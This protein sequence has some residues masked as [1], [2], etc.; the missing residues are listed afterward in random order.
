MLSRWGWKK[1]RIPHKSPLS[2]QGGYRFYR[3]LAIESSCDDSCVALLES[4]TDSKITIVDHSKSTLSSSAVGGI[5]PT[6]AHAFHQYKLANLVSEFLTKNAIDSKNPPDIIMC[7]R[8]PGLVGSLAAGLQLA[9]GL[10]IAWGKP[11]LGVHHMLGHIMM[12]VHDSKSL[13]FPFLSLLAS[14]GHTMLVLLRSAVDHEIIIDTM[15]V[16]VG[17]SLDKC[18]RELGIR[19]NMIGKELDRYVQM[20]S[21]QEKI[22]FD[23]WDIS[24]RKNNP[25]DFQLQLPLKRPDL[26]LV[27]DTIQFAFA[28]FQSSLQH[29][30][31]GKGP[32]LENDNNTDKKFI[33]YRL[34]ELVFDHIID[35]LNVALKK[36]GTNSKEYALCDSKF[37]GINDLVVSGGVAANSRLREKLNTQLKSER[38]LG[39]NFNIHIP[40]VAL[41]TDNAVMIGIAGI[42]FLK[43]SN[44]VND[45]SILPIPK[46]PLNDIINV[47][48]Y[49]SR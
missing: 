31:K 34:Q 42:E 33:A 18:G 48:G 12:A 24:K 2:R 46:W 32:S 47:D 6:E 3:A 13:Q 45:L 25:F 14:G 17:V 40:D 1:L 7:T 35:R 22:E 39:N 26:P 29:V 21:P 5:I 38:Y 10:S 43:A 11:L 15:D 8:G 19:G 44:L 30:R 28:G 4:D 16:A 9:K 36:H 41:C 49:I 27:P 23:K 37:S 20:I